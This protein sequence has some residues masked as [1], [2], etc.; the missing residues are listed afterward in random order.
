MAESAALAEATGDPLALADAAVARCHL[1]AGPDAVDRRLE[2][3]TA[4]VRHASACRQTRLELLGRRLRIEAL[5][6]R[7][8]LA[9]VRR[10][11]DEYAGRVTLVRDPRYAF[12]LPLWRATLAAADGDDAG[13]RRERAALHT[14]VEVLPADSDARLLARVQELFHLLDV[15][16]D[17]ATAA[18]RFAETWGSAAAGCRPRSPSPRRSSSLRTAT[19]RRRGRCS[20]A[21]PPRSGRWPATPSGCPAV[22]QL[23]DVARLT[24][25]HA[26]AGWAHRALQP[27][28]DLWAVEGIGAALRGPVSRAIA[29]LAVVLRRR[30][31]RSGCA[32]P[33]RVRRGHLARRLRRRGPAGE[34]Q[35]GHARHRPTRRA[36]RRGRRRA[37]PAS[38]SSS[39]SA[40]WAPCSTT[41]RAR[42]TA[43]ASPRS[44]KPS[45]PPTRAGDADRSAS[46]TA[47]RDRLVAELSAAV[48]LGG[49]A[50]PTG[51][52]AE[53]ARTTVTTRVKDALRRLDS[54]HPEAARHLRRSLRTGAFCRYDPD[55]IA[56]WEVAHPP[57]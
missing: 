21:G 1:H 10:A 9:E 5:F 38:V 6:E 15:D 54:A 29:A 47:E 26:L 7:G 33:A 49:R 37:R 22:V 44:T 39:S 42:P 45:T 32:R 50:R 40:T 25:G 48:G 8:D 23:A 57:A 12:F 34:G 18:R 31:P 46:L 27:Y 14:L 19:P 52:S 55:P 28:R 13:Y 36:P 17:P 43:A 2:D 41:P 30:G 20:T 56:T 16:G 53:R 3:A 4:V 11:V 35:Q 24:G 51:S